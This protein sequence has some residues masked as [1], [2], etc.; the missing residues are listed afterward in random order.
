MHFTEGG[1]CS[2][3][4]TRRLSFH[5]WTVTPAEDE[6]KSAAQ[7]WFTAVWTQH[8]S[9][10]DDEANFWICTR[11]VAQTCWSSPFLNVAAERRNR[12]KSRKAPE[13][14]FRTHLSFWGPCLESLLSW[15]QRGTVSS[16]TVPR[17]VV[18][19]YGQSVTKR[20]WDYMILWLV[21]A[22]SSQCWNTIKITVGELKKGWEGGGHLATLHCIW[23]GANPVCIATAT[24]L[25]V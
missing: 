25:F 12:K 9:S 18:F 14:I 7:R 11:N 10:A 3:T 16:T 22:P 24:S 15:T 21:F 8:G 5:P 20:N 17:A 1:P 23:T 13:A 19:N 4:P 6:W 2:Q